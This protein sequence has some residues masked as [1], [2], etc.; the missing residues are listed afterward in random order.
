MKYTS[1]TGLLARI[2]YAFQETTDESTDAILVASARHLAKLN[3]IVPFVNVFY[4]GLELQYVGSQTTLAGNRTDDFVIANLTFS[5]GD[6]FGPLEV[7]ATIFN[8]AGNRY[9]VPGYLEHTQ[10]VIKQDGRTFQLKVGYR[11]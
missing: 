4:T 7:S 11:Y 5:S 2:S 9:G 10:D 8:L 6:Y 1:N 3:L